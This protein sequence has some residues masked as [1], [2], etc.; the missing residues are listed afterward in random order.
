MKPI[1]V[2]P[3]MWGGGELAAGGLGEAQAEPGLSKEIFTVVSFS[4][5]HGLP[6]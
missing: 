4:S 5:N 6:R 3:M 2:S 1:S